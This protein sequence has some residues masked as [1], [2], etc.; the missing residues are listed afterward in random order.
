MGNL[1]K[2]FGGL[3]GFP[4]FKRTFQRKEGFGF[5]PRDLGR[6]RIGGILD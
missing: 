1:G 2:V 6:E 4:G 3:F 5:F